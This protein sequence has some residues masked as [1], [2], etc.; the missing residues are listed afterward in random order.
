MDIGLKI[1]QS[2]ASYFGVLHPG[3][4]RPTRLTGTTL[5]AIVFFVASTLYGVWISTPEQ[6][7][8]EVIQCIVIVVLI[9]GIQRF[10]QAMD[11]DDFT[12]L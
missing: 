12:Y 3:I 6:H 8:V 1:K 7:R 4:D 10:A 5:A 2:L 9:V 11:D